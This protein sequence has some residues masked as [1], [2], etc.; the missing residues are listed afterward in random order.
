ML[1]YEIF[2][3]C[4]INPITYLYSSLLPVSLVENVFGDFT[5]RANL[6]QLEVC[7][8]LLTLEFVPLKSDDPFCILCCCRPIKRKVPIVIV[9]FVLLA[10]PCTQYRFS[11]AHERN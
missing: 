2:C 11:V 6:F 9:Y 4:E 5:D 7:R 1:I 3:C 10:S 8:C